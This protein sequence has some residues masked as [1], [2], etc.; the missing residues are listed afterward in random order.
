MET[1]FETIKARAMECIREG[2]SGQAIDLLLE[3]CNAHEHGL[4]FH[5]QLLLIASRHR[6]CNDDSHRNLITRDQHQVELSVINKSLLE[7]LGS[8]DQSRAVAPVEMGL[9]PAQDSLMTLVIDR[10][11]EDFSNSEKDKL[12]SAIQSLLS[13]D[14]SLK[15]VQ[16]RAGSVL[17]TIALPDDD[18]ADQLIYYAL[19]GRLQT[20]RIRDLLIE[21]APSALASSDSALVPTDGIVRSVSVFHPRAEDLPGI[22]RQQDWRIGNAARFFVDIVGE[23]DIRDFIRESILFH[24]NPRD[25]FQ[26]V[27]I[28]GRIEQM[29]SKV[30]ERLLFEVK[31]QYDSDNAPAISYIRHLA[32]LR[33]YRESIQID[34]LPL[35]RNLERSILHFRNYLDAHFLKEHPRPANAV[36]ILC[37]RVP[38]IEQDEDTLVWLED[39][40]EFIQ[41]ICVE[42]FRDMAVQIVLLFERRSPVPGGHLEKFMKKLLSDH[43]LQHRPVRIERYMPLSDHEMH[44]WFEQH[45]ARKQ[46]NV[47]LLLRAFALSHLSSE[48]KKR[49]FFEEGKMD[50]VDFDHLQHLIYEEVEKER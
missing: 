12:L 38:D 39:Y 32:S 4:P 33:P 3:F 41:Q 50:M 17:L 6:R 13:I 15:I 43:R 37:F 31:D 45:N 9:M 10:N 48:E 36:M 1:G 22:V 11:L 29:L 28:E 20:F 2:E 27:I 5:N 7:L 23:Q 42:D 8:R 49:R 18:K 25:G 35:G 47:A 16:V 14:G 21:K 40:L 34:E 24:S 26:Y 30:A 19:E 46:G 44:N